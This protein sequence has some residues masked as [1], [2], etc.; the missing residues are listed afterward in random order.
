MTPEQFNAYIASGGLAAL[1][2]AILAYEAWPKVWQVV[3]L[4]LTAV[5][6]VACA[7]WY[8]VTA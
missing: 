4:T 3:I 1:F 5:A 6:L 7:Y 8:S 2:S